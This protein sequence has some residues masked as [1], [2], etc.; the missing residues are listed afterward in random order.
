MIGKLVGSA[1]F[2]SS[3]GTIGGDL[4]ISG[5]LTV[6]G[7]GGFSYSEVLTGDMK[8]TN[9]DTTIG[10]E[11]DQN[12]NSV[13]LKIENTG[14]Q[15]QGLYVYSGMDGN[16]AEPLVAITS[17]HPS[18]DQ[19]AL[20][21]YQDGVGYGV[22]IDQNGNYPALYIDTEAT[23]QHGIHIDSPTMTSGNC[24]HITNAN[25]LVDGGIAYFYSNGTNTTARNLVGIVNDNTAATGATGLNI[26]QDSTG[27]SLSIDVNNEATTAFT[28]Y[29]IYMDYD[30]SGVVADGVTGTLYGFDL[31]IDDAATN[32]AN[33]T[34]TMI[35]GRI[36]VTSANAQGT[37]KNVGLDVT[38]SG[39][40]EN[41]AGVFANAT[42]APCLIVGSSDIDDSTDGWGGMLFD[43]AETTATYNKAGIFFQRD[44][45]DGHLRGDLIFAVD[46]GAD[47]G[48]A[49][50]TDAVMKLD[51]NSRISLS[52][53]DSGG[54]GGADSTSGN[55]TLGYLA[56]EDI[57]SGSTGNTLIGH[58]SGKNITTGDQNVAIGGLALDALTTGGFNTAIG[59]SAL[60]SVAEGERGN[61]AIGQSTMANFDE[62]NGTVDDNIAIGYEAFIGADVLSTGNSITHNIAIG[63]S[64]LA[65]SGNNA[66]LGTVAIGSS[67]LTALT[68]GSQNT[69]LGYESGKALTIGRYNTALGWRA[70]LAEDVGDK[71]VAIGNNSLGNQE[72]TGDNDTAGNIGIGYNAGYN[73]VTGKDNVYIGL[74]AGTGGTGSNS[75]NV[76]VGKDALLDITTGL[77]NTCVGAYAG[78]S[79]TDG[80]YNVFLGRLAGQVTTGVQFAIGIGNNALGDGNVTTAANG[81]IAIGHNALTL[82]ED[83]GKNIAIGYEC[84][85][86]QTDGERNI[87][88][89]YGALTAMDSGEDGNIA[90]GYLAGDSVNNALSVDNVYIGDEAG[91]GG[92]GAAIGNIAIGAHAMDG[93][94]SN[95]QT[96]TIAIGHQALTALTQG[97]GNL[98]VGYDAMATNKLGDKNIAIGYGAMDLSYIDDTQDALTDNNIFIG[99]DSGG[100]DWATAG[101]HSNV[102]VGN[103]TMDAIMNG[104]LRNTALGHG[105]MS[106]LTTGDDN[107]VIGA[108]AGGILAR[109]I[110][111]V[112][113]G[114]GTD[115]ATGQDDD[116]NVIL[117]GHDID[118]QT[119]HPSTSSSNKAF[120][121]NASVTDVY[122]SQD[123]GATVHAGN[124][125]SNSNYAV[126]GYSTG[127]NVMRSVTFRLQ[128]GST[129]NT[130]I[131]VSVNDDVSFNKPTITNASNMAK[132]AT[133]NSFSLN[134]AGTLITMDITENIVGIISHSV[135]IHDLNS[136]ST[137]EL[138]CPHPKIASSNLTIGIMKRGTQG[139]TDWTA[140]LDSGDMLDVM[141]CFI[142]ST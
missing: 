133:S 10:L 116:S 130:N 88:I 60:S 21:V 19:P 2:L 94:T 79:I 34:V 58:G 74:N 92:T 17:D 55:T 44:G 137:S 32:H 97:A 33:A 141:I 40:D 119:T 38:V 68:T 124:V 134:A 128:P 53:N 69:A 29:G 48:N 122:M 138:Y 101:S 43:R 13:A 49:T 120:I 57:A 107:V 70:L 78:E 35:G 63:K 18:F 86:A 59:Y 112:F 9:A 100:G 96:G 14:N 81:T 106:S 22:K 118:L 1:G 76:G 50:I 139:Y 113:I 26:Q 84:L 42:S 91:R 3:G 25:S 5:D 47:S 61:I 131:N 104:A 140:I 85:D 11:I 67:A 110:Q 8:I 126:E 39:A 16:A 15:N 65:A 77:S 27:K 95:A 103:T 125:V 24:L 64:A 75:E 93:T 6:E 142:T 102:A 82:L 45:S 52:N 30:K 20:N 31:D 56:G 7:G 83:G 72:S 109:G 127:R 87:G 66:Q 114:A 89:G 108:G 117:I 90:I 135:R 136:S 37:L 121:G 132:D 105:A 12:G 23:S 115:L 51:A 98:A 28:S 80:D 54:T 36:N 123:S 129:P 111:N 62:G 99:Y 4:T 71:S 73:N 41:V 46:G